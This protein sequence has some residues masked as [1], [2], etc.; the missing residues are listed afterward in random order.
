MIDA[1]LGRETAL[2]KARLSLAVVAAALIGALALALATLAPASAQTT[3]QDP[4]EAS[5][6]E[7]VVGQSVT[8]GLCEPDGGAGG[9]DKDFFGF[10]AQAGKS[11]RIELIERGPGWDGARLH[12]ED[13]Y[14]LGSEVTFGKEN[15]Y[16]ALTRPMPPA[17][18]G[19][20]SASRP[21]TSPRPIFGSWPVPASA[22]R[23]WSQRSRGPPSP[24]SPRRPPKPWG[25]PSLPSPSP[26]GEARKGSSGEAAGHSEPNRPV[27][28]SV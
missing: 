6:V 3:C 2:H 26:R 22:T 28:R 17:S 14:A 16:S 27:P 12:I 21:P 25:P 23:S 15:A 8:R 10:A 1:L 13:F 5:E 24:P 18:A 19:P 7:L 11:Y 9:G 4:F 20:C